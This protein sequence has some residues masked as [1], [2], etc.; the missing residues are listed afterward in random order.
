MSGTPLIVGGKS[1]REMTRVLGDGMVAGFMLWNDIEGRYNLDRQ[2]YSFCRT[3]DPLI[4][5]G[6]S[7]C[8][9]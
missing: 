9:E 5:S 1:K 3:A 4:E 8:D 7:V 2:I 6:W